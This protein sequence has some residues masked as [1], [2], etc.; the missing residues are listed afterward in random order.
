[1]INEQLLKSGHIC[2]GAGG[3]IVGAKAFG[4]Q[5]VW[6]FDKNSSAVETVLENHADVKAFVADVRNIDASRLDPIDILFCGMPCQ[7]YTRI[8]RRR[9][10]EDERAISQ[11]ILRI[12]L[13]LKPQYLL[14]E[15]V[16]E[17]QKSV[18]FDTLN[19]EL[20][21]QGYCITYGTSNV[22]DYGIPQRRIRLFGVGIFDRACVPQLPAPT[23]TRN[24]N[25]FDQR[26]EWIKFGAIKDGVGMRPLSAKALKG[27][28][29]RLSN[30]SKTGNNFSVQVINQADMMMTVMG[31]MWRGSGTGSNS[32]LI[33]DNGIVRNVSFLEARRAQGFEDTYKFRGTNKEQWQMVGNAWPPLMVTRLIESLVGRMA[34]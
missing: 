25:L 29:R 2:C 18:G 21:N 4:I 10:E 9:G 27:V 26:P 22:A 13:V 17:Y 31:T 24:R 8:G 1:M 32:T 33:W 34:V 30:H 20:T 14:F 19:T 16:R 6:A 15:N 23:H 5:P 28:L 7:P 12:I 11:D 3:D